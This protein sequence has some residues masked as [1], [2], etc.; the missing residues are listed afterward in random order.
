MSEVNK[1]PVEPNVAPKR[2]PDE[3]SPHLNVTEEGAPEEPV[4]MDNEAPGRFPD[5]HDRKISYVGE[6][7]EDGSFQRNPPPESNQ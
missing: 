2:F 7:L 1:N 5:E 4:T 6:E 3:G